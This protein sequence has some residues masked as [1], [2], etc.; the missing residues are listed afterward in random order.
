MHRFYII[1]LGETI[2]SL[3]YFCS[4]ILLL[5]SVPGNISNVNMCL[6]LTYIHRGEPQTHR[7]I[8]LEA[9]A[10][11]GPQ[12]IITDLAASHNGIGYQKCT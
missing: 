2:L 1:N 12:T 3:V 6:N 5:T 7:F 8:T 4:Y 9:N 10:P 11:S